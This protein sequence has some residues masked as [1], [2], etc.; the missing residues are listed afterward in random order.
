MQPNYT[1]LLCGQPN[2]GK[3]T[4]LNNFS[5]SKV[6]ATSSKTAT[7]KYPLYRT[8]QFS[9]CKIEYVD[10]PGY[11]CKNSHHKLALKASSCSLIF[12]L[13]TQEVRKLDLL[14]LEANKHFPIVVLVN[15][16]DKKY[17]WLK[18]ATKIS[19]V[20]QP[21]SLVDTLYISAKYKHNFTLIKQL[22]KTRF[23]TVGRGVFCKLELKSVATELV[24]EQLFRLMHHEVPHQLKVA[25]TPASTVSN[26]ISV[27]II[28]TKSSHFTIL[29]RQQHLL[30]VKLSSTYPDL[31]FCLTL[32]LIK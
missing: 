17:G 9:N 26:V 6:S 13:V 31:R 23:K 10:S 12:L 2:S 7:T 25:V 27:S 3:S 15:K 5:G 30:E 4:F 22:I 24:R 28:A 11:C 1:V 19:K 8:Q 32:K 20:L 14:F 21:Y 29:T 18:V 16:V